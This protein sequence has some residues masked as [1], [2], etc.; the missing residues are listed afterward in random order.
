MFVLKKT[1]LVTVFLFDE[2]SEHGT[3][4]HDYVASESRG[5][6]GSCDWPFCFKTVLS[7]SWG[8]MKGFLEESDVRET[9]ALSSIYDSLTLQRCVGG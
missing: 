6:Y 7:P 1:R 8:H 5:R 2:I 3:C 9:R 4:C